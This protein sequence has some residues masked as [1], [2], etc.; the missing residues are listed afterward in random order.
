M[1]A[2]ADSSQLARSTTVNRPHAPLKSRFQIAWPGC[3]GKAG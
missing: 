1:K 3:E 2:V